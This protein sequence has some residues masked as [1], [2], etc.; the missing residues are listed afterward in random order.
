MWLGYPGTSGAPFMDY[1]ITD[2]V[3]SP[4]RL[5]H[6]YTEKLAYMPHTFFIGDHAQ[7]L[8]HLTE[9]VIL[10]DKLAPA[11]RDN[12]AVVNATNLEPL[13]SKADV[14]HTIRETE[15][16]YGPAKEKIKTEV[17]VPV[18]EVPTT[19]PL[20]QMMGG[21]LI[22]S[23]VVDGVHV[24][25]GLTQIQ[26][27]HK[28]ATGEEVPQSLLLTSRQ[29]YNLPEDAV[30]FCN[31]NQLYKIDPPTLD[32]WIKILK[33]VP[34]SVLW[35]LRFPFHGEAHV[36]KYCAERDIDTKRIVFSHVAAKEEHVRRGQLADVCL[37]TP[38]C[39]GHTTGMDILW[40]GTPMVT[41]PLETLASRVASSQLYALGV[42]ELVAESRED[43]INIAVKLGTDK[44]YLSAIRAK[45]WKARTTSTLF[46]VKQYCTDMETLLHTMWRRY[47]EGRPVDHITQGSVQVDF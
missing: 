18:V 35:L 29:Q 47:E 20:K 40:T 19:E 15:V 37:D 2:A 7:M 8:K 9:R 26:M 34:R 12:V 43:Y 3:T 39:N 36:H 25:N 27:H 1:I 44:N 28:A 45:V 22:A 30:V 4:L 21:S 31:F 23:S 6:A 24:H 32:M 38:L 33:R 41:M 16:V 17:V 10:K 11:E 42:P 46:N 14:K 13:L 5:A